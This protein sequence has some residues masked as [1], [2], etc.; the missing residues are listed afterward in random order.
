M[1]DLIRPDGSLVNGS[2]SQRVIAQ[3]Q[4]DIVMLRQQNQHL[5][6]H[7][8]VMVYNAGGN[9]TVTLEALK[10]SYNLDAD[11]TDENRA[12]AWSAR[13]IDDPIKDTG[14]PPEIF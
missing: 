8:A 4:Q 12:V 14:N 7:L 6:A 3:Q 13:L 5:R 11:V 9:V 1:T 2:Y 10:K